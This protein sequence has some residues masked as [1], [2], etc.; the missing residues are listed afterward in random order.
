MNRRYWKVFLAAGLVIAALAWAQA[1]E[2]D[3]AEAAHI[4][5]APAAL[6]DG[7]TVVA[8]S[9]FGSDATEYGNAIALDSM[10][11]IVVAG[12]TGAAIVDDEDFVYDGRQDVF[13]AKFSPAGERLWIRQFSGGTD[14]AEY[15]GGVATD[16][17]GNIYLAGHTSGV[18]GEGPSSGSNDAFVLKLSPDGEEVWACMLGSAAHDNVVGIAVGADGVVYF[19]GSTSGLLQEEIRETYYD[20]ERHNS[21]DVF[22]AQVSPE[23]EVNWIRQIG[24]RLN[25]RPVGIALDPGGQPVILG[26]TYGRVGDEHFGKRDIFVA[27]F[28]VEGEQLWLTQ[29]GQGGD[30]YPEALAVDAEGTCYIA[31]RTPQA[32]EGEQFADWENSATASPHMLLLDSDGFWMEFWPIE[33]ENLSGVAAIVPVNGET[34]WIG[35]AFVGDPDSQRKMWDLTLMHYDVWGTPLQSETIGTF[36]NDQLTD[37]A[38]DSEGTLWITGSTAGDLA[39]EFLGDRSQPSCSCRS[40]HLGYDAFL[41]GLEVAPPADE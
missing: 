25:D 13:V 23:G 5:S 32:P 41:A 14:S 7:L 30:D 27:K 28:A 38:V 18:M 11:N 21:N 24:I 2:I 9:Q 17:E 29:Y 36:W 22:L 10:G 40:A 8:Q 12:W 16:G 39:G 3:P 19:V 1:D 35:G 26:E 31:L 6:S 20:Q 33:V 37:M 4:D 34:V 15:V